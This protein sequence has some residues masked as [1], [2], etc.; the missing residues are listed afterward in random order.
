MGLE[1]RK[2]PEFDGFLVDFGGMLAFKIDPKS[3]LTSRGRFSKKHYF[4]MEK[5]R[6]SGIWGS[7]LGVEIR[8]NR[9]K[10]EVQHKVPLGI[11]FSSILVG[12]GRQ[13]GGENRAKID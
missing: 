10:F 8:K 13:I 6:F 9:C 5:Q 11:D 12:F 3:E 4:P 2:F 7:K 1:S